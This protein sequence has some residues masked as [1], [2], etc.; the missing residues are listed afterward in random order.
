MPD[1]GFDTF[2]H[3]QKFKTM[4][5]LFVITILAF[6]LN[7]SA[8]HIPSDVFKEHMII[9]SE[10]EDILKKYKVADEEG[11]PLFYINLGSFDKYH[12]VEPI[13]NRNGELYLWNSASVFFYDVPYFLEL[14]SIEE[15]DDGMLFY[16]FNY[17]DG[18]KKYFMEV[19]FGNR[20]NKWELVDVAIT[21]VKVAY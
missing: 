9:V 2:L 7:T 5:L 6:A 19:K 15:M 16:R 18:K 13:Q 11:N 20:Y 12:Q 10:N 17:F 3:L 21:K 1:F 4:K 8:Q 14:L